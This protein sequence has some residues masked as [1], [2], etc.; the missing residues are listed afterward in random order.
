VDQSAA[1]R[2]FTARNA[3]RLVRYQWLRRRHPGVQ[4][5]RFN[6]DERADV[7]IART[8][9]LVTGTQVSFGPDFTGHFHEGSSA[10][11]GNHIWF[12][13]GG[14]LTVHESVTIGDNCIFG[15]YVSIH[16]ENHV[17]GDD[18]VAIAHR[19]FETKPIVIGRNVWVGAK[20]TVLAGVTIGDNA[21]IAA[22]AVVTRDVEPGAIVGGIPARPIGR[23][24]GATRP[25]TIP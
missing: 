21:V 14:T 22:N 11:L 9:T 10:V 16:D 4:G 13:R 3:A 24:D 15:E 19:G 5:H 23:A 18:D 20:A 7:H 25:T 6:L 17:M 1:Q 8:A 2:L 12:S